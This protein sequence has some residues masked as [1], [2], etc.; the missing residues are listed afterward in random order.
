MHH[1]VSSISR[2]CCS[3]VF[4]HLIEGGPTPAWLLHLLP[5]TSMSSSTRKAVPSSSAQPRP[6]VRVTSLAGSPRASGQ[7]SHGSSPPQKRRLP[8]VFLANIDLTLEAREEVAG[9]FWDR[10]QAAGARC[11]QPS[12]QPQES[13]LSSTATQT[14]KGEENEEVKARRQAVVR[15]TDVRSLTPSHQHPAQGHCS[16]RVF[17]VPPPCCYADLLVQILPSGSCWQG[18]FSCYDQCNKKHKL[19][20]FM[21]LSDWG[22]QLSALAQGCLLLQE[23]RPSGRAV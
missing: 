16:Q 12:E 10:G 11:R 6:M 21:T 7:K 17:F 8:T 3:L 4:P 18:G 22:A 23:R 20:V 9:L 5:S 14:A 1:I 19:H 2:N 13:R 15:P